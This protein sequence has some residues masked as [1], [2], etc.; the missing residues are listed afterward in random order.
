MQNIR[1]FNLPY[2]VRDSESGDAIDMVIN[3]H[4]FVCILDFLSPYLNAT[5]ASRPA[6]R[7]DAYSHVTNVSTHRDHFR[8]EYTERAVRQIG[9]AM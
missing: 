5:P 9:G 6:T 7:R 4:A 2:S 8:G 1:S 3:I